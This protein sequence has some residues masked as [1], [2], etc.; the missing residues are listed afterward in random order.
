MANASSTV[1]S[2]SGRGMPSSAHSAFSASARLP[3]DR[4]ET[5]REPA[6][7][8]VIPSDVN[9]HGRPP[10]QSL[11]LHRDAG[12]IYCDQLALD[13]CFRLPCPI[14][15]VHPLAVKTRV[16]LFSTQRP[17]GPWRRDL[18]V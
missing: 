4:S 16:V 12:A 7:G 1:R 8:N 15:H 9:D 3:V 2:I 6:R 18:D 5:D 17:L 14:A 10:T 13:D 11:R